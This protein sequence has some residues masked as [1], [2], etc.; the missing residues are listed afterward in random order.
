MELTS[1]QSMVVII[2]EKKCMFFYLHEYW[3]EEMEAHR[4]TLITVTLCHK[5]WQ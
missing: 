3:V 4:E 5:E 1:K 2:Q